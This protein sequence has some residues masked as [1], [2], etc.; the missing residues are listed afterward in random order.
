MESLR[1]RMAQMFHPGAYADDVVA[2][3]AE[4]I[5]AMSKT[6]SH[7]D[8]NRDRWIQSPECWPLHHRTAKVQVV[9]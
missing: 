6:R 8:L 1:V 7:A 9:T 5:S 3:N 4:R 2:K